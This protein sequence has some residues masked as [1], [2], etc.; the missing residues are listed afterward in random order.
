MAKYHKSNLPT[1]S[2]EQI[3]LFEWATLQSGK[4]PELLWMFHVP[5]EGRR[6]MPTAV[7]LKREGLKR[8]VPDIFLPVPRGIY[9][10][11]FIELKSQSGGRR[12]NE[13]KEW[14]QFLRSQGYVAEFRN[15]WQ[16]AAELILKYLRW[17]K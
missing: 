17:R 14:I 9:H 4:Y 3:A 10:G 15:G 11:L 1:E 7:R 13:Q 5:N 16:A 12:S 8:G 6:S 2:E